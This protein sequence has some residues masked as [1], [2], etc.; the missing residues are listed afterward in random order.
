M[1]LGPVEIFIQKQLDERRA[2]SFL[3]LETQKLS[4]TV[5]SWIEFRVSSKW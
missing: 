5:E 2:G 3:F 1:K 4:E